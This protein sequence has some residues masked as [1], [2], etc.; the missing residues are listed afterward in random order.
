ML[1]GVDVVVGICG[2]S[3]LK[4]S[5]SQK[6]ANEVVCQEQGWRRGCGEFESHLGG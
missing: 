2:N 3:L 5:L 1:V 4:T 6:I